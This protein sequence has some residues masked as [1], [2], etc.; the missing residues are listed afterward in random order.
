MNLSLSQELMINDCVMI[1]I[2]WTNKFFII[3]I[4]S[5]YYYTDLFPE[6]KFYLFRNETYENNVMGFLNYV[7]R[8]KFCSSR[9]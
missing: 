3:L 4:I 9:V 1:I 6:T 5:A 2:S 8:S 7:A